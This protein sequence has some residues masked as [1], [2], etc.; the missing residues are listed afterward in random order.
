MAGYYGDAG[1]F[2]H[3]RRMHAE[4]DPLA[5]LANLSDAM[6]VF[7]CGILVALVVAYN[8]NISAATQVEIDESQEVSDAD[9]EQL[10]D[11]DSSGS[12]YIQKGTVYQDPHT[13]KLYLLEDG[14]GASSSDFSSSEGSSE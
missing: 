13:G 10:Q 6:L 7:A 1:S 9:I 3:T 11:S 4:S 5:G 2:R 12:G 8:V 14:D